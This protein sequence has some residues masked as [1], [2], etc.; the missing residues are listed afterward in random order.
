MKIWGDDAIYRNTCE[1]MPLPNGNGDHAKMN[2]AKSA[3]SSENVLV[4][5]NPNNGS[6]SVAYTFEDAAHT[7]ELYDLVGRKVTEKSLN[8]NEGVENVNLAGADSGVYFYKIY[9]SKGK[10]LFTGKLVLSK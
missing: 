2:K 9:D 4:S 8:G 3:R 10:L 1:V 7:F 6:F 5:P